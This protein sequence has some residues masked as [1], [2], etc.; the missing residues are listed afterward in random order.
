MSLHEY[1]H[2][3]WKCLNAPNK[4]FLQI[5]K[6]DLFK[7]YEQMWCKTF[8]FATPIFVELPKG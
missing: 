2:Y 7:P 5:I 3:F 6:N 4:Y 1:F 8:L